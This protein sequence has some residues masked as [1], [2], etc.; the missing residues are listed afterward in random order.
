M[1]AIRDVTE[2]TMDNRIHTARTQPLGDIISIP[3]ELTLISLS[4]HGDSEAFERLYNRYV[5]HIHRYV[6]FRVAD[7][8]SAEDITAHVFIKM[9]EKLPS[10][11]IG[12]SPIGAW[13][14]RIAHN[15][16]IDHYRTRRTF[17]S[18]EEVNSREVRHDDGSDEKLD[19]Q[20]K[21]EQLGRALQKL[22]EVQREVLILRFIEGF[23]T[24]EIASKL[25]KTQGAVRALQMRGLQELA[26]APSLQTESQSHDQ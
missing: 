24:Q 13:L 15:A 26:K 5:D 22:T 23:S 9:W 21:M 4:Q 11:Q 10:Y 25:G 16:V 14:Y 7:E 20:I 8:Q 18:L 3:D 1:S 19:L 2:A 17:V 6:F 12:K